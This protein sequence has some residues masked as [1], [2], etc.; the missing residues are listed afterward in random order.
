LSFLYNVFIF[1]K[2]KTFHF[3]QIRNTKKNEKYQQ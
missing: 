3:D 1:S 2:E